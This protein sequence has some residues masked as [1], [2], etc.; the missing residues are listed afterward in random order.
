MKRLLLGMAAACM[1]TSMVAQTIIKD[2]AYVWK[3]RRVHSRKS[4]DSIEKYR[5]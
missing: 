1:A 4:M 3:S 2:P 5:Q